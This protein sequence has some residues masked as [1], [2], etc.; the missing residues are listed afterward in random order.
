[1]NRRQ[2]NNIRKSAKRNSRK[3]S[4]LSYDF[5]SVEDHPNAFAIIKEMVARAGK[6]AATEAMVIGWPLT[7]ARSREIVRIKQNGE[8]EVIATVEDAR[9]K[10]GSF[11]VSYKPSTVLHARKK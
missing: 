4:L 7:V 3:R 5:S 9:L 10:S 6:N 1:M 2:I 11:Y 8:E